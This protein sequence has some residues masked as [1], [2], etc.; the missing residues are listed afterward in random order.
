MI[1]SADSLDLSAS[2][3]NE[4][5]GANSI[6]PKEHNGTP[7][8][9]LPIV[10]VSDHNDVEAVAVW[11]SSMH[12]SS[13]LNRLTSPNERIFAI[14]KVLARLSHPAPM[15]I[16]LRKRI[17][18]NVYKKQSITKT[19]FKRISRA[20][21]PLTKTSVIYEVVSSIPKAS[22]DIEDRESLALLA[23]SGVDLTACDG[24]SY[25]ERYSKSVSAVES[26][27]TLDKLRQEVAVREQ[28]AKKAKIAMQNSLA[29]KSSLS[30]SPFGPFATGSE[31]L[32]KTLSVPNIANMSQFGSRVVRIPI[33]SPT[34]SRMSTSAVNTPTR[35]STN[36]PS[37]ETSY[38][39]S[40]K[41]KATSLFGSMTGLNILAG[42]E[43]DNTS[44]ANAEAKPKSS[45]TARSGGESS[46]LCIHFFTSQ[47][48]FSLINI[49]H[50]L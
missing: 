32:R 31:A 29:D 37:L 12:E 9:S 38:I 6:L 46:A 27:L 50:P 40:F 42:G 20:D 30:S 28:M 8:F 11:D 16:V 34:S 21:I 15:N 17:C 13:H 25:I 22:E 4:T 2:M 48:I 5:A 1:F 35:Q 10:S 26:I 47:L 18:L 23:A 19:I 3:S 14:V 45:S 44:P 39:S 33:D 41:Q 7:F 43:G 49:C 24:E 36:D